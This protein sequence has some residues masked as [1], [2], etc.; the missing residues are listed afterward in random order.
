M[1]VIFL[2]LL[3][4]SELHNDVL[5]RI[6]HLQTS[7]LS[8]GSPAHLS[9]AATPNKDSSRSV[10]PGCFGPPNLTKSP[11]GPGSGSSNH[12]IFKPLGVP[13]SDGLS[14]SPQQ[15]S[16]NAYLKQQQQHS[17]KM[18][19][20]THNMR[21][22][23]ALEPGGGLT[24]PGPG[25]LGRGPSPFEANLGR[26]PSPPNGLF[27][28]QMTPP[29]S[30]DDM[31]DRLSQLNMSPSQNEAPQLSSK[32]FPSP[33]TMSATAMMAAQLVQQ[34]ALPQQM[35]QQV[36]PSMMTNQQLMMQAQQQLQMQQQLPQQVSAMP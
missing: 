8:R 4:A 14:L 35:L 12:S 24:N 31:A 23:L 11:Q 3:C 27:R 25:P 26:G 34:G 19:S 16:R 5:T 18:F 15:R 30:M 1:T 20:G 17:K 9:G 32:S 28:E 36:S 7:N 29:P 22:N 6:P 33:S 21:P 13:I 10:V 2:W